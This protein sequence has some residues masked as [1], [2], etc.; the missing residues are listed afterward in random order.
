MLGIGENDL[1]ERKVLWLKSEDEL[2][3]DE[4]SWSREGLDWLI[5]FPERCGGGDRAMPTIDEE[6]LGG[7]D[8]V[9]NRGIGAGGDIEE[10]RECDKGSTGSGWGLWK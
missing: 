2:L 9:E 6:G 8:M 7:G 5:L 1:K 3:S 4:A 10:S